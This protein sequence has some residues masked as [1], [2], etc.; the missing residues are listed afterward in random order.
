VNTRLRNSLQSVSVLPKIFLYKRFMRGA[1]FFSRNRFGMAAS[2]RI[3][4]QQEDILE[5]IGGDRARADA[6][7]AITL[8]SAGSAA[9]AVNRNDARATRTICV[10]FMLFLL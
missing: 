1:A 2:E 5:L 8:M 10:C 4:G 9:A 3:L 6:G 7:L